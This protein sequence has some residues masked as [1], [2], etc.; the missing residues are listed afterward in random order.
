[1]ATTDRIEKA[2]D[3]EGLIDTKR[4]QKV[5]NLFAKIVGVNVSFL[6]P[7]G[8]VLIRSN[9]VAPNFSDIVVPVSGTPELS[10]PPKF[11][12]EAIRKGLPDEKKGCLVECGLHYCLLP[13]KWENQMLGVF[14]IGPVLAAKRENEDFYRKLCYTEGLH[15]EV[16]LDR[17][18]EVK[19]YSHTGLFLVLDFL[20]EMTQCFLERTSTAREFDAL[21]PGFLAQFRGKE[22]LLS[23]RF[24]PELAIALLD[25]ALGLVKGDS[26]SVLL[27]EENDQCFQIQS[28]RGL[29]M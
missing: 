29:H 3:A 21:L 14:V 16:Y 26:G 5:Q 8:Q 23:L 13:V 24:S 15:A 1:M 9:T 25:I 7:S 19:L 20:H 4:W 17:I 27:L 18:R 2:N 22:S 28:A 11:V 10:E 6:D 12:M